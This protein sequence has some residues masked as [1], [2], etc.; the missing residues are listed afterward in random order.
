MS[1]FK[2]FLTEEPTINEGS[3]AEMKLSALIKGRL[4]LY[5]MRY[6]SL[7]EYK[8]SQ[9]TPIKFTIAVPSTLKVLMKTAECQVSLD[10]KKGKVLANFVYKMV[11]GK[12]GAAKEQSFGIP[13]DVVD[14]L[15]R[16]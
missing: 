7:D 10:L 3:G 11:D 8:N 14:E 1:T 16:P 2:E 15:L 12:T 6:P 9:K 5:G 13:K 4:D